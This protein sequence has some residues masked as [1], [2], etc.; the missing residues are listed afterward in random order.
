MWLLL[1]NHPVATAFYIQSYRE[2]WDEETS[3]DEI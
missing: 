3:I 1:G 2:I